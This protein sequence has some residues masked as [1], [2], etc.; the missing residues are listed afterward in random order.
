MVSPQTGHLLYKVME[1]DDMS[2]VFTIIFP[3]QSH[4][5]HILSQITL[6]Y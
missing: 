4:S 2:A 5:I 3:R 1:Y 6:V